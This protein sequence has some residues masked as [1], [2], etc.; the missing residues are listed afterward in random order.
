MMC[1]KDNLI[2]Y[3]SKSSLTLADGDSVF[4]AVRSTLLPGDDINRK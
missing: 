1:A 3:Y 2:Y 4:L